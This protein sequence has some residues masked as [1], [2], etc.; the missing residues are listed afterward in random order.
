MQRPRTTDR[1]V[2]CCLARRVVALRRCAASMHWPSALIRAHEMRILVVVL[3]N[4]SCSL[5][6]AAPAAAPVRTEIDLLLGRL[7]ASGCEFNRNGTWYSGA[8]ARDHLLRKLEYLEDKT[9][10]QSTEQFIELAATKSSISGKPYLVR[11]GSAAPVESRLWLT[12][13]LATIRATGSKGKP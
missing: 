9:T 1:A 10:V 7:Q 13:Q 2:L 3:A 6:F 5:A 11:C 4:L 12:G 8:D